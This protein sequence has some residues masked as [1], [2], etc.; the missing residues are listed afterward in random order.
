VTV[1]V[2]DVISVTETPVT[3]TLA[4]GNFSI[5]IPRDIPAYE[6]VESTTVTLILRRVTV[7][8]SGL[9]KDD[10]NLRIAVGIP[11]LFGTPR[12]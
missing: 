5:S 12:T 9:N 1:T 8:L 6:D 7:P 11:L 2:D 10:P 4:P 3:L